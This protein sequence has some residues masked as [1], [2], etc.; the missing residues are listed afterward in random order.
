MSASNE[1]YYVRCVT[2]GDH[3][4]RHADE[5]EDLVCP[6]CREEQAKHEAMRQQQEENKMVAPIEKP[7]NDKE[8]DEIATC[9]A[10]A[11][12]IMTAGGSL[13]ESDVVNGLK[14]DI[15]LWA[16]VKAKL[17][18]GRSITIENG[19]VILT[20]KGILAA[21]NLIAVLAEHVGRK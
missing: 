18:T 8:R 3:Y 21:I 9:A 5:D 11:T 17:L 15:G 2:C 7:N 19:T 4:W 14:G 20:T 6:L 10:V 1:G 13:K 12:G 16:R